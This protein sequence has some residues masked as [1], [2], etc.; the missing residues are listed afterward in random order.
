V[1]SKPC[2]S[3][4]PIG[5]TSSRERSFE[6]LPKEVATSPASRGRSPRGTR[7]RV[8]GGRGFRD[9]RHPVASLQGPSPG[10]WRD[11][12]LPEG[13]VKC[14]KILQYSNMKTAR[15]RGEVAGTG[16]YIYRWSVNEWSLQRCVE[17]NAQRE[18]DWLSGVRFATGHQ[19][20]GLRGTPC[21]VGEACVTLLFDAA[22]GANATPCNRSTSW[23]R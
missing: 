6:T 11:R 8:G 23:G 13:E 16:S 1:T 15:P 9:L 18:S 5:S 4:E 12:P 17:T 10:R 21:D 3:P 7:L 22:L 14:C 20:G 2:A 19:G